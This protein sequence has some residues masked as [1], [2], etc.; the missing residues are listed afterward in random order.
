M[1]PGGCGAEV[2][3]RAVIADY[4]VGAGGLILNRHLRGDARK[5]LV[6]RIATRG[7]HAR[8]LRLAIGYDTA[9]RVKRALPAALV[10]KRHNRKAKRAAR[11]G[12]KRLYAFANDGMHPR[13][14]LAPRGRIGKD[15]LGKPP[16]LLHRYKRMNDIVGIDDFD[17]QLA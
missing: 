14:K 1:E 15:S 6:A 3:G 4:E 10:E 12:E 9:H 16:P 8:N 7:D 2:V 5:R 11:R 17:A 13:F